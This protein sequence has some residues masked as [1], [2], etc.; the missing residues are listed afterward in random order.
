[1]C[2]SRRGLGDPRP[3][4][5]EDLLALVAVDGAAVGAEELPGGLIQARRSVALQLDT[6][7]EALL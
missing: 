2:H 5:L 7:P 4:H 6:L 3:P 1:M